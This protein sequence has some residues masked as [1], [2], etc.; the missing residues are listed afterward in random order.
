MNRIKQ[1]V[2]LC[3]VLIWAISFSIAFFVRVA[4]EV[5]EL[6]YNP[7]C[8]ND[9]A[10]GLGELVIGL[11]SQKRSVCENSDHVTPSQTLIA[12]LEKSETSP[13]IESFA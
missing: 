13:P 3:I 10:S 12:Y 5:P 6:M 1:P 2:L 9:S 8:A 7:I 11:I 4:Y